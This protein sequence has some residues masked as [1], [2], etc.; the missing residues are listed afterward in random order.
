MRDNCTLFDKKE[1]LILF[2]YIRNLVQAKNGQHTEITGMGNII[3]PIDVMKVEYDIV[4]ERF[5][6]LAEITNRYTIPDDGCST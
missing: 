4:G 3:G 5:R 2:P 6:K 1:E